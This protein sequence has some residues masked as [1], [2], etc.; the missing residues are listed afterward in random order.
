MIPEYKNDLIL[1]EKCDAIATLT[2]NIQPINL[3]NTKSIT[4]MTD[5]FLKLAQDVEVRAVILKSNRAQV[6][7][8]GSDIKEMQTMSGNFCEKK[9]NQELHML[10]LIECIS[11]PTLCVIEGMCL[12]GGLELA[13]CFDMRIASQNA[14]FAQPEI[15][16]GLYP[17]GGGLYR[18]P[19]LV[20]PSHAMEMMFT[21]R[22][23]D[24]ARAYEI[25]LVN[26][27]SEQGLAY[28]YAY[29][30]AQEITAMPPNAIRAI[31]EGIRKTWQRESEVAHHINIT[32]INGVFDNPNAQEGMC[33][34]VEKRTPTFDHTQ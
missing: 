9:F 21:G 25:G 7:C 18:L 34:F 30:M 22:Q 20:G 12:G 14:K 31:K 19:R 28:D 24:A 4:E 2:L 6:F 13:C 26:Y 27:V 1:V 33:A 16:L 3:N 10:D 17:A 11:K 8:A 32:Y 5:V 29:S 15:K 23:I